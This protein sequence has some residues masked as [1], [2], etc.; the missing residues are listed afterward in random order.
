MQGFTHLVQPSYGLDQAG[1]EVKGM[2]G[3]KADAFDAVNSVDRGQ[4]VGKIC[5]ARAHVDAISID[6]LAQQGDFTVPGVCQ[7]FDF[8]E[9]HPYGT[10]DLRPAC[11][12][13]NAER[14]AFVTAVHDADEGGHVALTGN[15]QRPEIIVKDLIGNFDHWFATCFY[16]S[17]QVQYVAHVERAKY[18]IH[19][20]CAFE[21]FPS[22]ALRNAAANADE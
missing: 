22:G 15:G 13:D 9:N 4:Q 8:V 10:T 5:L 7:S 21:N 12:R 16:L 2:R 17:Y 19:V 3:N 20:R 11:I 18:Q 1:C 6:V 14:A